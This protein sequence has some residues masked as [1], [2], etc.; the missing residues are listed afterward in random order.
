M[1]RNGFVWQEQAINFINQIM[2][3]IPLG[4]F[5]LDRKTAK[6]LSCN[7]AFA[8]IHGFQTYKEAEG[9]FYW[10]LLL[11]MDMKQPLNALRKDLF[12]QGDIRAFTQSQNIIS[13]DLTIIDAHRMELIIGFVRDITE[14]REKR[15]SLEEPNSRYRMLVDNIRE[16]LM[17]VNAQDKIAFANPIM[18]SALD[19]AKT[20]LIG[21]N[22]SDITHPDDFKLIKNQIEINKS[23]HIRQLEMRLKTKGNLDKVFLISMSPFYDSKSNYTGAIAVCVDLTDHNLETLRLV[24]IRE[25][26]LR[27]MLTE[28]SEQLLKALGW[29]DIL[30]SKTTLP[31]QRERVEKVVG[32]IEN[33]LNL[34]RQVNEFASLKSILE[35]PLPLVSL[36]KFQN[37]LIELFP[38]LV[39]PKGSN[40]E[41]NHQIKNPDLIK[42]PEILF[43]AI[44]QVVSYSL[45]RNSRSI[46]VDIIETTDNQIQIK[47]T[48]DGKAFLETPETPDTSKFLIN[49]FLTDVLL[50]QIGGKI[51]IS[52]IL[53]KDGLQISLVFPKNARLLESSNKDI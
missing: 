23:T 51:A 42:C 52:D 34:S 11:P 33:V 9:L 43:I 53:P 19:Y 13:I 27:I 10:H 49:I 20:E 16:G 1:E 32:V 22:L 21:M 12:F 25:I 30:H 3:N 40:I 15:D 29:L 4:V 46:I 24:S 28:T 2:T 38:P 18:C 35:L 50:K 6:I 37:N 5:V 14:E 39:S 8:H 17:I 47:I 41:F 45:L 36:S 31:D 26:F 48:D 44:E 7:E